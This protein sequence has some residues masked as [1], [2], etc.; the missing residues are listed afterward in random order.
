LLVVSWRIDVAVVR[1][2]GRRADAAH[3]AASRWML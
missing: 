2:R 3:P 1:P